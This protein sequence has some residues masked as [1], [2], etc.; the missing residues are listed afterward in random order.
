MRKLDFRRVAIPSFIQGISTIYI[1]TIDNDLGDVAIPS[2]IQG[3]STYFL[4]LSQRYVPR[5]VAIPS[6]I[7][8]IST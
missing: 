4:D 2:F 7:Q 3:I 8:G 5:Y 1:Q 6:F